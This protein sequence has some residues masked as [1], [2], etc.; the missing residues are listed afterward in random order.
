MGKNTGQRKIRPVWNSAQSINHRNKFVPSA[1]LTRSGRVPVSTAKQSSLRATPLTST[2][3]P[4]NVAAHTNRVNVSKLR[5]DAFHKSHSP[6]R[7]HFHKSI[8]PNTSISNEK[9]NTVRVKAPRSA[10]ALLICNWPMS[11]GIVK[12]PGSFSFDGSLFNNT[13]EHL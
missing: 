7:R 1:V 9:V 3:R 4:V 6:I 13:A 12:L 5:T 11:Q 10:K 2:F 8:A